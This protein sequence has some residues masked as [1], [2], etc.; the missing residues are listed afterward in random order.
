MIGDQVAEKRECP[1]LS[2]RFKRLLCAIFPVLDDR[3]KMHVMSTTELSAG[4]QLRTDCQRWD[5]ARL[6]EFQL[7]KLNELLRAIVPANRFYAE[8]LTRSELQRLNDLEELPFTTKQE[9]VDGADEFGITPNRTY[10][11]EA[12]ARLHH[13]SGTRGRPLAVLDTEDDWRWWVD[14]WQYVLDAAKVTVADRAMM[15][16]SFGPFIGFWSANDA[17]VHR[18][19]MVIPGGGM[20]TDARIE[21]LLQYRATIVCCTPTYALRLSEVA[22]QQDWS[23]PGCAVR[24]L[25]VAGEPGG[26]IPAVREQIESSWGA[27]VVDHSGATEVG[28][29]GVG[30]LMGAGIHVIESHFCAEFISVASGQP[31][32]EGELSELVL[33]TLGRY[34]S[35]VI[36]Y[37]TG[38]LVRPIWNHDLPNRFVLLKGG[39]LGRADDMLIIRGVNVFP[40]SIE[41]ILR[42][43]PEVEEFR[44]TA[45]RD[46]G[47]DSLRIEVEDPLNEPPRIADRLQTRL[48]VRV[49]VVTVP[50]GTLPRFEAKSRRFID[51]RK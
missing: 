33:T 10:S 12:Y 36:R 2:T 19:A 7:G 38:D 42:E 24:A 49:A 18:G 50:V 48:G 29:W 46:G 45:Y 11:L 22:R 31:A 23:L 35:P 4:Q 39:V 27:R 13:T 20:S 37:R 9:L 15:A 43:F 16:F 28:P 44:V 6:S 51:K 47:L 25:I 1:S 5:R 40:S 8:K 21:M 17:L 41:A 32:K 26:S 30:D 14:A 3:R 34:G